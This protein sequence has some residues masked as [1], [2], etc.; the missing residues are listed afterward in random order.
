[1]AGQHAEQAYRASPP[2]N[3]QR[4]FV[5][6]IGQPL[7]EDLVRRA[8][9]QPGERV[10]DVGCGTG[11]VTRLAAEQVGRTGRVAGLDVNAG[12]L[13]VAREVTPAS[14]AI[15]WQEASADAMPYADASFD[16]VLCQMAVQFMPDRRAA[17][18]EMHRVLA[19]G[20][21][22]LLNVTGP[23]GPLFETLARAMQH[24]IG[25]EAA[26]FVRTVFSLHEEPE[27]ERLLRGAGFRN[28]DLH[29][30]TRD[31]QLPPAR[32]FLWQYVS[33]TPLAQMVANATV[34]ARSALEEE[35]LADWEQG[36]AARGLRL[37]QRVVLASAQRIEFR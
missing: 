27:I 1:M 3:Y 4:F 29:A 36:G 7:A 28:V 14:A 20:G 17:L 25:P 23:A 21:R 13:A 18:R 35:V 33:S 31:L 12:M 5:P 8:E 34:A 22:L 11:V 26:G 30:Y 6:V 19:V 16:V 15:E 32:D 9:L 2:E 37:R 24:H 10:L